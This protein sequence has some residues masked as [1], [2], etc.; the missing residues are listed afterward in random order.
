MGAQPTGCCRNDIHVVTEVFERFTAAGPNQNPAALITLIAG[1]LLDAGQ[2]DDAA[3]WLD[4]L[5]LLDAV[6]EAFDAAIQEKR[7]GR[8]ERAHRYF[9]VA[10]DAVMRDVKALHEFAQVK[11]KLADKA[12]RTRPPDWRTGNRLLDEAREMLQRV[13]QMD[14]PPTRHAWAWFDLGRVLKWRRAPLHEIR[15]AFQEAL[16]LAPDEPRFREALTR[17]ENARRS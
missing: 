4:R 14:A 13:V 8:N 1:A 5:P 6:E 7:A 10:G 17:L 15:H 9:Q 12:R 3:R 16:R 2:R 11:M